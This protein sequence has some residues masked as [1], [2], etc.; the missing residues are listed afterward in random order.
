[1]SKRSHGRFPLLAGRAIAALWGKR[2][3]N[4]WETP[5]VKRAAMRGGAAQARRVRK[6][7]ALIRRRDR[8]QSTHERPSARPLRGTDQDRDEEIFRGYTE[9]TCAIDRRFH[10]IRQSMLDYN[11]ATGGRVLLDAIRDMNH[12]FECHMAGETTNRRRSV[13]ENKLGHAVEPHFNRL[14]LWH[15]LR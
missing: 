3:R 11:E 10:A 15:V 8:S 5:R 7:A 9:S 12:V 14:P 4:H 6:R 2:D 1:M 13:A